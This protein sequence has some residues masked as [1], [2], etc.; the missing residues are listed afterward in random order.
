MDMDSPQD[1]GAA[2]G[3][4]IL[5]VTVSEEPPPPDSPLSRVRAFTARYGEGALNPEHIR[6]A[7][8]GRPLL[9]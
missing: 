2:F 8:E 5:G 9:P 1:V 7:Q 6:A 3:A 4:L